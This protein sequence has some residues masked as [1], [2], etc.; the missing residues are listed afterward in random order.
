[1][2]VRPS[3]TARVTR[4][5][6][7]RRARSLRPSAA[8]ADTPRGGSRTVSVPPRSL[9]FAPFLR[10]RLP[11]HCDS[12]TVAHGP[13]TLRHSNAT[14]AAATGWCIGT[15]R[16]RFASSQPPARAPSLL[17][18]RSVACT[19][20]ASRQHGTAPV[21]TPSQDHHPEAAACRL[22]ASPRRVDDPP[23]ASV[24]LHLLRRHRSFPPSTLRRAR[25]ASS[26]C[27]PAA[28]ALRG[29]RRSAAPTAPHLRCALSRSRHSASV[30]PRPLRR[31]SPACSVGSSC[32]RQ[33]RLPATECNRQS[34]LPAS[35]PRLAGRAAGLRSCAR[36]LSSLPLGWSKVALTRAVSGCAPHCCQK[37]LRSG[38]ARKGSLRP[39]SPQSLVPRSL[40]LRAAPACASSTH[41]LQVRSG[42]RWPGGRALDC[43][44]GSREVPRA[45]HTQKIVITQ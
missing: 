5:R 10:R 37:V 11:R 29:P 32:H 23:P 28:R 16:S 26:R 41:V 13:M 39:S 21:D 8:A 43:G 18:S 19:R 7:R 12:L 30:A 33:P 40:R 15:P 9:A 44:G 17:S 4:P 31:S 45:V 24:R 6:A 14:P 1:M 34:V 20:S 35:L 3:A 2:P 42:G 22:R 36:W 38:H 25:L 27:N